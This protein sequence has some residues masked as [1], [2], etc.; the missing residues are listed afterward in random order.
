MEKD[1]Q[2]K[3]EEPKIKCFYDLSSIVVTDRINSRTINSLDEISEI[4]A[5]C[6]NNGEY[7]AS[8]MQSKI[9]HIYYKAI[10]EF[11]SPTVRLSFKEFHKLGRPTKICKE[12]IIR[13][14]IY[15]IS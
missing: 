1:K 10:D 15:P 9:S 8:N 12:T 2:I 14:I 6:K 11:L 13:N 7:N 5:N 4:L 3:R